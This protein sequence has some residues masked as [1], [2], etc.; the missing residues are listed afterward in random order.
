VAQSLCLLQKFGR[1]DLGTATLRL[2]L[3]QSFT[4]KSPNAVDNERDAFHTWEG[5][6]AGTES[7]LEVAGWQCPGLALGY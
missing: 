2:D 3:K 6:D 7:R 4:G 5:R 1:L